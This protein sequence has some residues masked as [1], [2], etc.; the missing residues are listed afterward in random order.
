MGF[1]GWIP[2][3]LW[4]VIVEEEHNVAVIHGKM[5]RIYRILRDSKVFLIISYC[6]FNHLA[7]MMAAIRVT[8]VDF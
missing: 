8:N 5:Q 6:C 2:R 7:R 4:K 1:L 3:Y